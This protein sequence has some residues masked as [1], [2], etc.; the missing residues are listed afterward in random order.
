MKLEIIRK[1]RTKGK[2]PNFNLAIDRR[3]NVGIN[4]DDL[5][6]LRL[7]VLGNREFSAYNINRYCSG[8]HSYV[9]FRE[10]GSLTSFL[11]ILADNKHTFPS[12]RGNFTVSL[13]HEYIFREVLIDQC[14]LL[15]VNVHTST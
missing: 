4:G 2:N 5:A 15:Y 8:F 11:R 3:F 1:L 14:K 7:I 10:A 6:I 12:R 9:F 13:P